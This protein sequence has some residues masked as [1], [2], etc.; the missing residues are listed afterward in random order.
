MAVRF[1]PYDA[2]ALMSWEV[3]EPVET[4]VLDTRSAVWQKAALLSVAA[5]VGFMC[6]TML[7]TPATNTATYMPISIQSVR[8]VRPNLQ[9][10]YA[11]VRP[12]TV[13]SVRTPTLG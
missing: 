6:T 7:S 2:E 12:Y 4:D 3:V 9:V 5:V 13:P 10:R 11:E 8:T 1:Q